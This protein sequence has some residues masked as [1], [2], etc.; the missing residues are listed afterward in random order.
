MKQSVDPSHEKLFLQHKHY[1]FGLFAVSCLLCILPI[2]YQHSCVNVLTV[3]V[4]GRD[5]KAL[6]AGLL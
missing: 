4:G 2:F 3:L 5:D 6:R 1:E